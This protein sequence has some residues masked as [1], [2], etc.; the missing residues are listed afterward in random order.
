MRL[1][2]YGQAG[3]PADPGV[4]SSCHPPLLLPCPPPSQVPAAKHRLVALALLETYVRYSRV[5]AAGGNSALPAVVARFLDSRG[6]GHPCEAV[7]KRAAY[8]F[9]RLAKQ[10]RSSLRPLVPDILQVR[11]Q[12]LLYVAFGGRLLRV[13][14]RERRGWEQLPGWLRIRAFSPGLCLQPTTLSCSLLSPAS[15]SVWSPT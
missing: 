2:I 7:A 13:E 3:C 8:L 15:C 5:A 14:L 6:M 1:Q 11:L 4:P 12:R 9:C 10:L